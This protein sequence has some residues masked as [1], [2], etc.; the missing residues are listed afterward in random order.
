MSLSL[1]DQL[2]RW[3]G[4]YRGLST[5]QKWVEARGCAGGQ[6]SA[7][8]LALHLTARPALQSWDPGQ[9]LEQERGAAARSRL[10]AGN[11]S[12][13]KRPGRARHWLHEPGGG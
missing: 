10:W 11:G 9:G 8:H 4:L 1:K 7:Q 13:E 6:A 5:L 3:A 12:R 2:P